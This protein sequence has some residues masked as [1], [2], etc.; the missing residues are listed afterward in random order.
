MEH[1][2]LTPTAAFM[3]DGDK[4]LCPPRLVTSTRHI[5]A[6]YEQSCYEVINSP[7]TWAHSINNCERV[8]GHLIRID[9]ANKQTYIDNFWKRHHPTGAVW[10]DLNDKHVKA[11]SLPLTA[12]SLRTPTGS[13]ASL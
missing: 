9:N 8:G 11:H 5:L 13:K 10:L 7:T 3:S 12:T 1:T 6:V 2:T 4:S